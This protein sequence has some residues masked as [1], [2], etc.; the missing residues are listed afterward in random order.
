MLTNYQEEIAEYLQ[1]GEACIMYE[2]IEDMYEKASYYLAHETERERIA[3]RGR[4]LVEQEFTFERR[5][6]EMLGI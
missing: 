2:S 3:V 1:P 5:I 6:R 4:A